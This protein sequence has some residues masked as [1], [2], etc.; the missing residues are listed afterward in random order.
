M[1][2]CPSLAFAI[3]WLP[4]CCCI[5]AARLVPDGI[6]GQSGTRDDPVEW[7]DCRYCAADGAGNV[8]FPGG[9]RLARGAAAPKRMSKTVPGELVSDGE[10][11]YSWRA[12]RG[13]LTRLSVDGD[14][15]AVTDMAVKIGD[16]RRRPFLAP[17]SCRI[18]YAARARI[19]ALDGKAKSILAWDE[20]GKPLGKAFDYG[21]S[22]PKPDLVRA[23]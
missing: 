20:A 3:A 9:W 1:T 7:T 14:G 2:R 22:V 12:D 15:L 19:F 23:A 21:S 8:Y 10:S 13:T 6:L 11:V 5:A 16:W 17:S 18:G 4:P